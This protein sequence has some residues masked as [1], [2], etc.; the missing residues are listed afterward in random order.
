M[1]ERKVEQVL[2]MLEDTLARA[3]QNVASW[4]ARIDD[5]HVFR[6]PQLLVDQATNAKAFAEDGVTALTTAIAII[7]A[8]KA[9]GDAA[10]PVR[11]TGDDVVT[12]FTVDADVLAEL[13]DALDGT[14]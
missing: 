8:A 12:Y 14:G 6:S 13:H 2:Q 10:T 3:I 1:S 9:V 11:F 5:Y 7:K 4:S